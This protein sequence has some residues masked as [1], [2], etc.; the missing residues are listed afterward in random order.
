MGGNPN[1]NCLPTIV[2]FHFLFS[3]SFFFFLK[4]KVD[5]KKD[6]DPKFNGCFLSHLKVILQ[7]SRCMHVAQDIHL[8]WRCI[9]SWTGLMSK[10]YTHENCQTFPLSG[11]PL[12]W[13]GHHTVW[14]TIHVRSWYLQI[15]F[16]LAQFPLGSGA[17][18]SE[19]IHAKTVLQHRCPWAHW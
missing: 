7:F 4:D 1:F 19:H 15:G 18:A 13:F 6:N 3:S 8:W 12:A 5:F 9:S 11:Q 14:F 10:S 17:S 2:R 16:F